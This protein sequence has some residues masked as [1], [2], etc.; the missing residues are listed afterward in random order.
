MPGPIAAATEIAGT[1]QFG[2]RIANLPEAGLEVDAFHTE[3][4]ELSSDYAVE[5][6]AAASDADVDADELIDQRA[7][8]TMRWDGAERCI[9]GLITAARRSQATDERELFEITLRSPLHPLSR[10]RNNRIWL[11]KDVTAIARDVLAGA[12]IGS[13][14]LRL[15]VAEKPQPREFVV[16]YDET[17]LAFLERQLAYWGLVYTIEQGSAGATVIITDDAGGL[18]GQLGTEPLDYE[19][20]SQQVRSATT[21]YEWHERA[22]VTVPGVRLRDYNYEAPRRSL[23]VTSGAQ[24]DEY[25]YGEAYADRDEGALLAERRQQAHAWQGHTVQ[26]ATDCRALVPGSQI[27]ASNLQNPG[28]NGRWLVIGARLQGDQRSGRRDGG[29]N[30]HATFTA[31]LD[32][33]PASVP[34]RVPVP[35]SRCIVHGTFSARIESE[36]GD[37]AHIDDMGRYRIRMPFDTSERD[38]ARASHPVRL[39]QPYGGPDYGMHFPLHH[40]TEVVV[41]CVNGDIDRPIIIGAVFNPTSSSPV[42]GANPSQ[43]ILRTWGGNE[44]L[45][46]DKTDEERV[47]LFTHERNNRLALDANSELNQVTLESRKGDVTTYAGLNMRQEAGRDYTGDVGRDQT[48]TVHRDERLLTREGSISLQ[49]AHDFNLKVGQTIRFQAESADVAVTAGRDLNINSGADTSLEVRNGDADIKVTQGSFQLQ[50][51][52]DISFKGDGG[53]PITIGQAGGTISIAENGNLSIE[54][55]EVEITGNT[56]SI[57]GNNVGNNS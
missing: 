30:D 55:P 48:I 23:E 21:L 37:Y 12:G 14:A 35:R 51:A 26:A 56:I 52:K 15:K 39:A 33:I 6:L 22:A 47:E 8:L 40:G 27:E 57:K 34:Y 16:Q 41:S 10:R 13:D 54:G 19:P 1:S 49:A 36:G 24:A 38:D 28:A 43:N 11:G 25:R 45:M 44:L 20:V 7:A 53:G 18:G 5:I 17:D 3:G 29:G 9:H 4:F 31:E 2:L 46:E 42:T 32:L 50:A